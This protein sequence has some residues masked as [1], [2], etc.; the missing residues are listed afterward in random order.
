MTNDKKLEVAKQLV[1]EV[2]SAVRVGPRRGGI[3]LDAWEEEL[4][5]SVRALIK[6]RRNISDKQLACLRKIWDRV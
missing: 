1:D 5:K 3:E 2:D 6:A 4:V